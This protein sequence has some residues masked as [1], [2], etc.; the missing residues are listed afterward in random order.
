MRAVRVRAR[1]AHR[2]S[3]TP[4]ESSVAWLWHLSWDG[5]KAGP[6]V[7]AASVFA[8]GLLALGGKGGCA[9]LPRTQ[10]RWTAEN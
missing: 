9:C 10:Q 3:G 2:F 6:W 5:P 8:L 7:S 4:A 1:C